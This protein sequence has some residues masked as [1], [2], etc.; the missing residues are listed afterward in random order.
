[1]S[2]LKFDL[3]KVLEAREGGQYLSVLVVT[4]PNLRS[5]RKGGKVESTHLASSFSGG[6]GGAPPLQ[7]M[8][9]PRLGV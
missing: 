2:C 6:S 9:V 1:M 7:H 3:R 8:E 5:R 4:N